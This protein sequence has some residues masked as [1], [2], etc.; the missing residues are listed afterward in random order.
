[1]QLPT[2]A[3]AFLCACRCRSHHRDSAAFNGRCYRRRS[4]SGCACKPAVWVTGSESLLSTHSGPVAIQRSDLH[5]VMRAIGRVGNWATS[6][7]QRRRCMAVEDGPL[8]LSPPSTR[9]E[10]LS[11]DTLPS[12]SCS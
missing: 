12:T 1:M 9:H 11:R 5:C 3:L 10:K 2:A 6:G 4:R 8:L 7:R